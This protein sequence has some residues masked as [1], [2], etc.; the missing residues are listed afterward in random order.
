MKNKEGSD[1]SSNVDPQSSSND[2]Q[3]SMSSKAKRDKNFAPMS[4]RGVLPPLANI[5]EQMQKIQ[6][7]LDSF[8]SLNSLS[9][10]T[11]CINYS[12]NR[13]RLNTLSPRHQSSRAR[14]SSQQPRA[15]SQR[16]DGA[17]STICGQFNRNYFRI[18]NIYYNH[19]RRSLTRRQMRCQHKPFFFTLAFYFFSRLHLHLYTETRTNKRASNNGSPTHYPR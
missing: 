13:R 6:P 10:L 1:F 16:A 7:P 19:F 2:D 4:S 12:S 3:Q 14:G 8:T 5:H 17:A 15:Y 18:H 9:F 11:P